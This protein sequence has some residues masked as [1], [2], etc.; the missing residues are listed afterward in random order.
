METILFMIVH[1][2]WYWTHTSYRVRFFL[3]LYPEEHGKVHVY[4]FS[5]YCLNGC[6][7]PK[8]VYLVYCF[9][10]DILNWLWLFQWYLLPLLPLVFNLMLLFFQL[11]SHPECLQ[12]GCQLRVRFYIPAEVASGVWSR[13]G[14]SWCMRWSWSRWQVLRWAP[15]HV[16]LCAIQ[17]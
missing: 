14:W 12:H 6:Y 11:L 7:V 3:D 10:L 5:D 16:S 4:Q 9:V 8:L 13:G 15:T 1:K 17:M 2:L